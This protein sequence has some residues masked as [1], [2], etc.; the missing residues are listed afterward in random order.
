MNSSNVEY[1]VV[2][3]VYNS[4]NTLVELTERIKNLFCRLEKEYEIILVDDCSRDSSWKVMKKIREN[5]KNIKIIHLLRNFG[6]HNA[7]VCGFNHATGKYVITLDDDFQHPPEEI[8]KLIDKINEGYFVVYGKYIEKKHSKVENFLSKEFQHLIH[9]ILNIPNDIYLS[10]FVIYESKV[11]KNIC[12]IKNSFPFLFALAVASSPMNKISNVLV[13]H[14]ERKVGKSNYTIFKYIKYSL[15]LIINYSSLPLEVMGIIGSIIS[16][17]SIIFGI[18]IVIK[19]LLDPTYGVM[20]WNS[21]I[22]AVTFLNGTVLMSVAI[23]GEY[24]KRILAESSYG[25]PYVIDEMEF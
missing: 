3:P 24:L 10:S 19:K 6:Q 22:V 13:A 12:N 20:G 2:I 1:S 21:L 5:D 23:V 9:F 14:N 25:Q 7:I 4:E 18:S 17:L 15:N 11:T 8:P 16:F